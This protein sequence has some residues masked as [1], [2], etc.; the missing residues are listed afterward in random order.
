MKIKAQESS[1]WT[2][3]CI[4]MIVCVCVCVCVLFDITRLPLLN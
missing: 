3:G 2:K 4:F 1:I